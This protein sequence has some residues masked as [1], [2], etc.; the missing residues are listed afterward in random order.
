MSGVFITGTDTGV[1]K[2]F[3][4]LALARALMAR[5]IDVGVMKPISCGPMDDNDAV[6]LK[7]ELKIS[8]PLDLINPIRLRLPLAPYAASAILRKKIDLKKI[9]K[10]FKKLLITHEIVLV[11]GVGGV[12]V[13]IKKNY[14]AADLAKDLNIPA[15]IVAR[16]GLGTINHTLLTVEAL[17]SRKVDI[18]GI[19]MNGFTGKELSEKTNSKIIENIT[20]IPVLAKLRIV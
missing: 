8:D 11:E 14:F 3:I 18:L 9:F 4:T 7:K 16:A 12:L 20:R 2:T 17:R 13:P 19:I 6:Y 5:G 1:G 10:A 15:I